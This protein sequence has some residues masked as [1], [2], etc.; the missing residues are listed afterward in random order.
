[1]E[2]IIR[3]EEDMNK[4]GET[5]ARIL[6]KQDVVCLHGVLGAGKTTLVRGIARGK[7]YQGRVTSPTFTLMNIYQAQEPIHHFD[8]YRLEG[9]DLIDL[10]MED[11]LQKELCL[12]EWPEV[13]SGV[14][15]GEAMHIY[16]S[17]AEEDYDRERLVQIEAGG[18]EGRRKIKELEQIVDTGC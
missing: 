13:G 10:G 4:L 1:M 12:I 5:L 16:I 7:G 18:E 17:L 11:Y 2:L 9:A 3:T 6:N 14:L 8:F 15:P